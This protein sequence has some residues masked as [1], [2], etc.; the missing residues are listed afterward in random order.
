M[1]KRNITELLE[2]IYKQVGYLDLYGGSIIST[3][4]ILFIFFL[5][6]SYFYIMSNIKPIKQN[7]A[8]ERCSPSVIPFAGLI[9][10]PPNM[11]AFEFTGANFSNCLN[12]ILTDITGEFFQPIYYLMNVIT[13]TVKGIT[14]SIQAIRNKLMSIVSNIASIDSEIMGKILG[15]L[16]PIR[17]M[18]IK[19][20]DSLAKVTGISVASIYSVIG[21]WLSIQTFIRVFIKMVIDG[22]LYMIGIIVLLWILPFTWELAASLTVIFGSVAAILG[23]VIDGTEGI[24]H[25]SNSVPNKPMCF[26]ENT[27][28]KMGNGSELPIKYVDVN[29]KLF[30]GGYVTSIFKVSQNDMEMYDYN[31]VI[32]SGN[33]NVLINNKW[34]SVSDIDNAKK[35]NN[36]EKPYLYCL[37]TTSKKII[38]K[39]TVFSDWDDIEEHEL[40]H[41]RKVIH[42]NYGLQ[43]HYSNIHK[44]LEGGFHPDTHIEMENGI[45]KCISS[46]QP[47]DILNNG[48]II[49]GIVKISA[50]D[51]KLYKY[52]I[53]NTDFY[54]TYNNIIKDNDVG[55]FSTL[56]LPFIEINEK[57]DYF[58]H[59]ITSDGLIWI[60]GVIFTDYN[61]S[62]E[63]FLPE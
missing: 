17:Q 30:D 14:K 24:I 40:F 58:Y 22:L 56:D 21:V 23:I 43:I 25:D 5:L 63:Y 49:K 27:M 60:N 61:G 37:N 62:L 50:N 33:H 42:E 59:L 1:D 13:Q 6:L 31:S 12:N 36:Y 18:I 57:P 20:K 19:V 29:M 7:W 8:K 51:I 48:S 32:V 10:K 34:V 15:V 39:E 38:I 44:Y 4:V 11:T 54:G 41:L 47:N 26:D 55:S 9:N 46:L 35:L 45:I 3:I 52:D 2:K 28:I 53:N 16:T